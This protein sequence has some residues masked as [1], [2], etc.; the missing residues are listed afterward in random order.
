[1]AHTSKIAI[2]GPPG[3]IVVPHTATGR[4]ALY[5]VQPLAAAHIETTQRAAAARVDA[6]LAYM[7][8]T[9]TAMFQQC[10]AFV[11]DESSAIEDSYTRTAGPLAFI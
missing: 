7:P 9:S 4:A 3:S 1:M 6:A 5:D 2:P 11:T 10:T 8:P